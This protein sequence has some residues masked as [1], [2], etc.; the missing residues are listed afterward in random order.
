MLE[1]TKRYEGE[2]KGLNSISTWSNLITEKRRQSLINIVDITVCA[3]TIQDHD[4]SAQ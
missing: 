2:Q 1:T 3:N 4:A